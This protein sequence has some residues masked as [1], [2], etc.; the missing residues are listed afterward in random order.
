MSPNMQKITKKAIMKIRMQI[1]PLVAA[2]LLLCALLSS[3]HAGVY[4]WSIPT[5]I[6]TADATLNQSGTVVGAAVFGSF[7]ELVILTNG[8]VFDFKADGSV[9][10]ATGQG[11][12][13]GAFSGH[14]GN[15]K[16]DAALGQA[17][18][19]GGPK[20]ITL[21]NLVVGQQYSVQLFALDQRSGPNA[22][23]A[24]FQDPNDATDI[25]TNFAMGDTVYVLGTFIAN[26][27][28]MTIQENLINGGGGNMNALVVRN[29]SGA[30]F[31]PQIVAQ[32]QSPGTLDSGLS[33]QFNVAAYGTGPLSYQWQAGIVGS[34][35]FTNLINGGQFSGATN[36]SLTI[37]SVNTNDTA[38]Y[39]VVVSNAAGS[40]T[41]TPPATLTVSANVPLYNW[42]LP[43]SITTADATLNQP[44]T[45]VGAEVFGS[46][47]ELVILTNSSTFDFKVD[48]SI[49]SVVN[50]NGSTATATGAFSGNTGNVNF[51]ATLNQF[52]WD[53]GPKTITLNNLVV[54]QQ[55]S[56]Q[57]FALDQRAGGSSTVRGNYQDPNDNSDVSATFAMGDTVYVMGTFTANN[58]TMNIMENLPDG[59]GGGNINAVVVRQLSGAAIPPQIVGEPQSLNAPVGQTVQFNVGVYGTSPLSYQW[60]AGA[61]NSG[62]FTNLP[63]GGRL[64]GATTGILT[65]TNVAQINGGDYRVIVGNSGGSVTSAPPATLTVLMGPPVYAWSTPSPIANADTTLNLPGVVVGA[66]VFGSTEELVILTNGSTF[67]FKVDGS[68]ASVVNNNGS[69]ATATGAFNGNTGNVNFN[70]AL[71]QFNWDGGPKTI[72]LNNLVVG[73]QYSVQLFALDQRGETVPASFQDPAN[74]F[75]I[76][77][78]IHM[79]DTVYVLGTFTA[80][81][82]TMSIQEN[83]PS[84]GGGNIN[85]LVIRNLSGGVFPPQIVAQPQSPGTSDSGL[86]VQFNVAAYG[87][88]PLS[89]QWRAG[90]VGSGVFTNLT[91]GGQFSGANGRTLSI[92]SLMTNNTAD[93]QVVVSN[94][95]GS[96]T[97]APAAT[98]TVITN[99]GLYGWSFPVPITTADATLN[100]PGTLV[101]AAVFGGVEHVVTLTGGATFDFT[102]DGSVAT[103]TGDGTFGTAF[104]GSTGNANFNTI[105]AEAE[106]DGGPK[107]ITLNNLTV[108]Q[109]YSVQLFAVD[110]RGGGPASRHATYQDPNDVLDTSSTFTMGGAVYVMGR[111][112]ANAAT[113]YIEENLLDGNGGNMNALVI[114][115]APFIQTTSTPISVNLV[116]GN[117]LQLTWPTDHIGWTLEVQTNSL[118]TGLGTNWVRIAS[119]TATNQV[120]VPI[121]PANGSVFYRLV[122]P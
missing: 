93:Y 50:N 84:G 24:N 101:G 63:N 41:S 72:T 5:A 22:R 46:T 86:N 34:G 97:S 16:F 79:N 96:I 118:S 104:N 7:E 13:S 98:L 17:E 39:Q 89:Y 60:Q 47:E 25:S 81:S 94:V 20:T 62:I 6:T 40:V 77:A 70:A 8:S 55:Y 122:Y 52:N 113:M 44:G 27:S 107:L 1:Q 12:F 111:F 3:G 42:S 69:T 75:D 15:K 38:D 9:A 105:L 23:I 114:R 117:S 37:T 115:S 92:T 78:T 71:N 99:I 59:G 58:S 116:G 76:S 26:S 54:G 120:S 109:Q 106:Y 2:C 66:E 11:T 68:I 21:N 90:I 10:T 102:A 45:V 35:V 65:I 112:T 103:A 18:Y 33:V 74:S 121:V 29:L 53:G 48:G 119:S 36:Y 110:T 57:L 80:N 19:D 49:A 83:L 88:A 91:N 4:T 87:T 56:V 51:N 32:P 31:P 61:V 14:T 82:S 64:S 67:D 95:G 108:G 43:V 100:Q 73:Q 30:V 85:A 28:T